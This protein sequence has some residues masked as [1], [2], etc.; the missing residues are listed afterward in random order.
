MFPIFILISLLVFYIIHNK[1]DKLIE[2]RFERARKMKLTQDQINTAIEDCKEAIIN[3]SNKNRALCYPDGF[4]PN[5]YK[6]PAPAERIVV[7]RVSNCGKFVSEVQQ[8]DR[9]R[10]CGKGSYITLWK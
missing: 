7:R 9:K 4:V 2:T 8:Y 1:K 5:A 3:S 6:W 10:S